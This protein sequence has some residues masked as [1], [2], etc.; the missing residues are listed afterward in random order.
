MKR[1]ITKDLA[2]IKRIIREYSN[3][4]LHINFSIRWDGSI[5]EIAQTTTTHPI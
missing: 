3:S 1:A 5:P 4:S 2:D